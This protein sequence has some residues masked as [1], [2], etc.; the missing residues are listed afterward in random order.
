M[1]TFLSLL[2]AVTVAVPVAAQSACGIYVSR[3]ASTISGVRC[4]F[5]CND[6]TNTWAFQAQVL[7]T[8]DVRVTGDVNMP[9]WCVVATGAA[10]TPCPGFVLPGILN[11]LQVT[12]N[13]FVFVGGNP[14]LAPYRPGSPCGTGFGV[15]LS[16]LQIPASAQG[17]T[18]SFQGL[19]YANGAP[20]FTRPLEMTVQ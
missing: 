16:Q 3:G 20:T 5:D 11:S 1:K 12:P 18:I 10:Y 7:D 6:P 14:S 9:G 13:S 8:I 15:V 17:A 4:D 2:F 19:V